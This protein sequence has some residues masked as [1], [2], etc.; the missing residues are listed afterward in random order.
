M[1]IDW[2]VYI[3]TTS[4]QTDKLSFGRLEWAHSSR[5]QWTVGQNMQLNDNKS[6]GRAGRNV[7][8][9]VRDRDTRASCIVQIEI[10]FILDQLMAFDVGTL[11]I[12]FH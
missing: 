8:F 12:K 7:Q 3:A 4:C 10:E 5:F 11:N 9:R 6:F 2:M 1:F